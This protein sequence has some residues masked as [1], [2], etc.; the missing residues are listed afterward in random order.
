MLLVTRIQFRSVPFHSHAVSEIPVSAI[1]VVYKQI[2]WTSLTKLV[3]VC[4]NS[5]NGMWQNLRDAIKIQ[6]ML[7][8]RILADQTPAVRWC[9]LGSTDFAEEPEIVV[10]RAIGDSNDEKPIP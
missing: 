7:R 5:Y 8:R 1:V 3:F 2:R 9:R 6:G 10:A 4:Q